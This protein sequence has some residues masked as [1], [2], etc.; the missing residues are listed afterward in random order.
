M[1]KRLELQTM[2]ESMLGSRNVY[3][4]PPPTVKMKYPAIVY[5][6]D[7]I[8]NTH[9]DNLVYKQDKLYMITLIVYD[10]DSEIIDQISKLPNCKFVRHFKV[11]NLNH[12]N[13]VL[14]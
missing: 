2:F 12:Y 1:S 5:S 4:Q 11:D 7:R 6:L 14:Y 8:E 3:F 13:F 10:P 9:A